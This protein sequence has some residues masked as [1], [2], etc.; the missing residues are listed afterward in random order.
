MATS[1]A[2]A[3]ERTARGRAPSY[4]G[5]CVSRTVL[6]VEE[7]GRARVPST[8]EARRLQSAA[9]GRRAGL[10][11]DDEDTALEGRRLELRETRQ[12]PGLAEIVGLLEQR[13][14]ALDE[15]RRAGGVGNRRRQNRALAVDDRRVDDLRRDLGQIRKRLGCIHAA[16]HTAAT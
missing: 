12:A 7:P 4:R 1:L 11:A 2:F 6:Y 14:H 8:C 16:E 10:T 15:A 13:R 3:T 9:V 5:F